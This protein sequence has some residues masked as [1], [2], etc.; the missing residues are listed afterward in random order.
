MGSRVTMDA[1]WE[2]EGAIAPSCPYVAPP[3]PPTDGWLSTSSCG[4]QLAIRPRF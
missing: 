4:H 3:L 1:N 2:G